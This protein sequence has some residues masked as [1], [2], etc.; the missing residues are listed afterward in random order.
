MK[1]K[2]CISYLITVIM[3]LMPACLPAQY[4]SNPSFEGPAGISLNPP[5]WIPFDMFSTPDTEPLECDNFQA[6]DGDT[7]MTLVV[8]GSHSIHPGTVENSQAALLQPL[9]K[10]SKYTISLDLASRD[11]L[12]HYVFGEGF[13]RYEAASGLKV[14]GSN[15]VSEK[16]T[17]VMEI[18][19][20][21]GREW[22]TFSHTFQPQEDIR[23]LL[24]EA[25]LS[26]PS[27][28]WGNILIDHMIITFEDETI[29]QGEF[30]IPNVFT[31]NG[32]AINDS[33]VI[34]GLPPYSSLIILD[35][36]GK[37]VFRNEDYQNQWNGNG[38]DGNPLPAD[39][40]W[41][42]LITPGLSGKHKG[43]VY[44]KRD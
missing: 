23:Y 30:K 20:V 41:Y 17:L 37:E 40:Y 34:K 26:G 4:L 11:N 1:P 19:E 13:I 33:F 2:V 8:R 27:D 21:I 35:R 44:L 5:G 3:A 25:G 9:E 43:Y 32:D 18:Q 31:P 42:I 15:S 38:M 7:Y 12:G 28:L 6:S 16:G 24:L 39:T 10:G 36:S 14:Y 29:V 22:Q